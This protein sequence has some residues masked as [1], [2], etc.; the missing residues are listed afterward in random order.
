MKKYIVHAYQALIE[1]G[2]NRLPT[3][4]KPVFKIIKRSVFPSTGRPHGQTTRTYCSISQG[5]ILRWDENIKTPTK[6]DTIALT[7]F[8]IAFTTV[9]R[10]GSFLPANKKNVAKFAWILPRQMR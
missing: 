9:R 6:L 8:S 3:W 7:I 5:D 1:P 2:S 10:V 4:L